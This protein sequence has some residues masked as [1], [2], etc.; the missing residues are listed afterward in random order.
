LPKLLSLLGPEFD[1]QTIKQVGPNS[2]KFVT[3]DTALRINATGSL[4]DNANMYFDAK[5]K[6][7]ANPNI[8]L[9]HRP[10]MAT[11]IEG[12]NAQITAKDP[13]VMAG[14]KSGRL[15]IDPNPA[16]ALQAWGM[17]KDAT[18]QKK[19][20][21]LGWVSSERGLNGIDYPFAINRGMDPTAEPRS[22]WSVITKS[23]D[24]FVPAMDKQ[25]IS[26]LWTS[27]DTFALCQRN[28]SVCKEQR[29]KFFHD[30]SR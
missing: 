30:T 27:I 11:T 13:K 8:L 4:K 5:A 1:T 18:G 23:K 2:G 6:G 21:E 22:P 19:I 15:A 29:P 17:I 26:H 14:V 20:L 7:N 16:N 9:I 10:E 25:G 12:R 24:D 3:G 28:Q